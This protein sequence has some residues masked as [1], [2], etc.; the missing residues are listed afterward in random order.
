MTNLSQ[1]ISFLVDYDLLNKL[2]QGQTK[3]RMFH[4]IKYNSATIS[5]RNKVKEAGYERWAK[6]FRK[7]YRDKIIFSVFRFGRRKEL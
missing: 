7:F 5:I 1:F 6:M 3:S 2:E 4:N